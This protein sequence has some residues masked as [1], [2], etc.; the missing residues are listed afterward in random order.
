LMTVLFKKILFWEKKYK[1]TRFSSLKA[2][3]HIYIGE[4]EK[5]KKG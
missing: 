4:M 5:C 1:N 3:L 2:I